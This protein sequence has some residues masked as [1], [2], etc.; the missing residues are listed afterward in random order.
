MSIFDTEVTLINGEK[1]SMDQWAG[2]C[3]LIVNTA[4]ECGYTRSWRRWKS[5]MRIMR[6][7]V[8]S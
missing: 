5:F 2:H 1:A 6:C 8:S 4:S 3:L 7:V